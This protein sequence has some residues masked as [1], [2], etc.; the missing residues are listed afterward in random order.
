MGV[1]MH[2]LNPRVAVPGGF[3]P[4]AR[5]FRDD[6]PWYFCLNWSGMAAVVDLL[7][8]EGAIDRDAEHD[9]WPEQWPE[10]HL[11]ERDAKDEFGGWWDAV[12]DIGKRYLETT[13][14]IKVSLGRHGKVP[15]YKFGSNDAW[16]ITPP[17]CIWIADALDDRLLLLP[18]GERWTKI[19]REFMAFNRRCAER[20]DGY[21]ID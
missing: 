9:P 21:T 11:V 12:D 17:E 8:R 6:D 20:A 14:S 2:A 16:V 3:Q 1:D 7:D 15:A 19:V 18:E 4:T 13:R 5:G 10:G